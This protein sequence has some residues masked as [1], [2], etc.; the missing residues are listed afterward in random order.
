MR[1]RYRRPGGGEGD[2]RR[3]APGSPTRSTCVSEPRP[4]RSS[5]PPSRFWR[6]R[7]KRTARLIRRECS[8]TPAATRASIRGSRVVGIGLP[9]GVPGPAPLSGAGPRASAWS[10]ARRVGRWPEG[11]EL[12]DRGVDRRADLAPGSRRRLL[13]WRT[14]PERS[15]LK[16]QPERASS[17]RMRSSRSV[18]FGYGLPRVV[19][20][21]SGSAR[22]AEPE[23]RPGGQAGSRRA[24]P[25]SW[26]PPELARCWMR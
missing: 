10:S 3:R 13:S 24:S 22:R 4:G 12:P 23:D 16:A 21:A 8:S 25:G 18:A 14:C 6:R 19:P 7:R 1:R 17:A 26:K 9:A 5:K 2:R 15:A 11:P 20:N